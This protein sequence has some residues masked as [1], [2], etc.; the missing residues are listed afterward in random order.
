M[1]RIGRPSK[2]ERTR[3]QTKVPTVLGDQVRQHA[4]ATGQ[5]V[6][7][8]LAAAVAAYLS[9]PPECMT[10]IGRP[11]KGE[12]TSFQTKVPTVLGDQVRQHATATGQTV[13]DVVAAAV[14]AYL[15]TPPEHRRV[16]EQAA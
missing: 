4:T 11:S 2:G 15:S 8:V 10:R 5:T 14:A 12:R 9:T 1:T 7:D 16:H 13:S 6:L 3:F